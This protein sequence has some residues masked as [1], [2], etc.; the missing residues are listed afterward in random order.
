M[1]LDEITP[2]DGQLLPSGTTDRKE[3]LC[4]VS[5]WSWPHIA[6]READEQP[7]SG[8]HCP[9]VTKVLYDFLCK[10][11]RASNST[12]S[13]VSPVSNVSNAVSADSGFVLQRRDSQTFC[14]LCFPGSRFINTQVG[15]MDWTQ[16]PIMLSWYF[17]WHLSIPWTIQYPLLFLTLMSEWTTGPS[18]EIPHLCS[19]LHEKGNTGCVT[20]FFQTKSHESQRGAAR[21]RSKLVCFY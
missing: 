16:F 15:T 7:L 19:H 20:S 14:C 5:P 12:V 17:N 6:E 2:P 18:L 21:I 1:I 13:F 11:V 4:L 3:G 8:R 9:C 10:I